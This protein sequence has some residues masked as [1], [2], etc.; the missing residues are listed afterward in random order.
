[1]PTE[2]APL[3]RDCGHFTG[4]HDVH[5]IQARRSWE[6]PPVTR[7]TI[8]TIDDDGTIHLADGTT[9]WNHDPERLR[10]C[11]EHIGQEVT[12]RQCSIL[13]IEHG[14]GAALFSVRPDYQPCDTTY[15]GPLPG[16]SII[17]ELIRRGGGIRR[18]RD[19]LAERG[20]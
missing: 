18:G 5:F 11:V 20:L 14:D 13:A 6:A 19:L 15:P 9:C 8:E 1:M 7:T 10:W 4:G 16:E 2:K 17:E 12:V 3:P